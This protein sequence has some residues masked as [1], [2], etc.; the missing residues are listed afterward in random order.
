LFRAIA[1]VGLSA[2]LIGYPFRENREGKLVPLPPRIIHS[3][4]IFRL[5]TWQNVTIAIFAGD[6]DVNRMR[7]VARAHR[8]LA[9]TYP[10]G[11][12][13]CTIIKPGV[14]IAGQ[15]TRDEAVTFMKELGDSLVR[16]ALIIEDTGIMA[17]VIR[18]IVRGFN[19]IRRNTKLVLCTEIDEA[20]GSL[21]PLVVPTQPNAN[22]RA[23][24][25]AAVAEARKGYE[26]QPMRQVAQR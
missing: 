15:D 8:E 5:A 26:P 22:V 19:V 9:A 23:E 21:A 11:I 25:A 17:Q 2:M 3:D 12:V 10:N 18:T 6:V 7:R 1:N 4:E 13:S 24:L 14:P 16:S 20:I